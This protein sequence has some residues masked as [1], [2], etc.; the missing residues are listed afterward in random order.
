MVKRNL[1]PLSVILSFLLFTAGCWDRLEIEERGFVVGVAIDLIET[2]SSGDPAVQLTSQFVVPGGI[3]TPSE[4]GGGADQE[5][6]MNF[7]AAGESLF[8][9]SR[10]MRKATNYVPFYQHLKVVIISEDVVKEPHLLTNMMD[11]FIRDHDMRRNVKLVITEGEAKELLETGQAESPIP[12]IYID[13]LLDTNVTSDTTVQPAIIGDIHGELLVEKGFIIP[14][15]KYMGEHVKYDEI[16]VFQGKTNQLVGIL[17]PDETRGLNFITEQ[18]EGGTLEFQLDG[19][20]TTVEIMDYRANTKIK[21]EDK[22]NLQASIKV[23]VTANIVENFG[24]ESVLTK[25]YG[26]KMEERV[27]QE[28]E[29]LMELA[30]NRIQGELQVDVLGMSDILYREHYEL[31]QEVKENWDRGE[32]YFSQMDLNVSADVTIERTGAS[33]TVDKEGEEIN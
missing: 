14:K 32:N 15:I 2:E 23:Q 29:Q 8:S 21:G 9:I 26:T 28:V 22:K 12:A 7:T 20:L 18:S 6:Y 30:I 1:L 5:P 27:K 11:V 25:E 4:G 10:E 19:N 3:G 16:G 17:N 24:S 31:W 13:R 33:D